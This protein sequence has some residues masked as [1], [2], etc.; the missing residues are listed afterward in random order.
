M[1]KPMTSQ[2]ATWFEEPRCPRVRPSKPG[3]WRPSKL[4]L[5]ATPPV[6]R[7]ISTGVKEIDDYY[8]ELAGK[9]RFVGDAV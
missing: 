1:N 4:R 9:R 5:D 7:D 3:A 6:Q 2:A 8:A